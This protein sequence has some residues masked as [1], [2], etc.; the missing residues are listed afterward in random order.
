M[1]ELDLRH[2]LDVMH[3]EKNVCDSIIGT[4]LNIK[5]KTKD[6]IESRRDLVTMGIRQDL[7]PNLKENKLTLPA[8]SFTLSKEEKVI[9]CKR[10]SELKVPDGYSSNIANCV[11]V[12]EC[13]IT[14]L[15]SHDCHVLMQQ[16]LPVALR[17][18][19]PSGPRTTIFRICAFFNQL[20]QRVIDR[21]A[22]EKLES[23]MY[24]TVCMLE[25]YYLPAF[26]DIMIHLTIHL[27]REA[28]LCGP[29]HYRWMFPFER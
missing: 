5:G 27:G 24:E 18:L 17:N 10:L 22:L 25:M 7:Q 16:L 19:L 8:A 1:Q 26:F 2:N 15:K 4:L 11:S 14:G 28:R 3:I 29:A 21:N 9:F 6:G 23:D 12:E 13:K 20:C